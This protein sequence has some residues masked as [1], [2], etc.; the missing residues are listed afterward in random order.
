MKSIALIQAT[1]VTQPTDKG[2]SSRQMKMN[3]ISSEFPFQGPSLRVTPAAQ[4]DRGI[5][6]Q[7]VASQSTT[8][9]SGR[10][11]MEYT[12][13]TP[14]SGDMDH[15]R[16]CPGAKQQQRLA[17][18]LDGTTAQLPIPCKLLNKIKIVSAEYDEVINE[19]AASPPQPQVPGAFPFLYGGQKSELDGKRKRE[20]T[21]NKYADERR[22]S[23]RRRSFQNLDKDEK[24]EPEGPSDPFAIVPR[25]TSGP[26]LFGARSVTPEATTVA[27][28]SPRQ[29]TINLTMSKKGFINVPGANSSNPVE[30]YFA[31]HLEQ[32][33][34]QL[35]HKYNLLSQTH[36]FDVRPDRLALDLHA[37]RLNIEKISQTDDHEFLS[38]LHTDLVAVVKKLHLLKMAQRSPPA[39]PQPSR[40]YMGR[41]RYESGHPYIHLREDQITMSAPFQGPSGR[42]LRTV[43][44]D[45]WSRNYAVTVDV[46][47]TPAE[48]HAAMQLQVLNVSE[49][50]KRRF[51]LTVIRTETVPWDQL[52]QACWSAVKKIDKLVKLQPG[53]P[54]ATA[55]SDAAQHLSLELGVDELRTRAEMYA[56]YRTLIA[57]CL[58]RAKQF[59]RPRKKPAMDPMGKFKEEKIPMSCPGDH[60]TNL[61]RFGEMMRRRRDKWSSKTGW[62]DYTVIV[63]YARRAHM[64][65]QTVAKFFHSRHVPCK[66]IERTD[67]GFLVCVETNPGPVTKTHKG[68]KT[69]RKRTINVWEVK[70]KAQKESS[71]KGKDKETKSQDSSKR[72]QVKTKKVKVKSRGARTK[73]VMNTSMQDLKAQAQ[74]VHDT[75]HEIEKVKT[76]D[77]LEKLSEALSDSPFVDEEDEDS[78]DECV[79]CANRVQ[80]EVAE[81]ASDQGLVLKL[82]EQI[83]YNWL[84]P[85]EALSDI[86]LRM[87]SALI[88]TFYP[89]YS[90]FYLLSKPVSWWAPVFWLSLAHCL[91]RLVSSFITYSRR[92]EYDSSSYLSLVYL[93]LSTVPAVVLHLLGAAGIISDVVASEYLHIPS[94]NYMWLI[95]TALFA[96]VFVDA[97][98]CVL[99]GKQFFL[100][101]RPQ[102]RC[103]F[104]SFETT[105][106]LTDKRWDTNSRGPVLHKD[107]IPATFEFSTSFG[108]LDN[109]FE[110][111]SFVRLASCELLAQVTAPR[112]M[113]MITT[114]EFVREK[115]TQLATTLDS[116][117][118]SRYTAFKGD[119]IISNTSQVAMAFFRHYKQ[120]RDS[121]DFL[122]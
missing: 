30:P 42:W 73:A 84:A 68:D 5:V 100:A 104:V 50:D 107:P 85:E 114:E 17:S 93:L 14:I 91:F 97:W 71:N 57:G 53:L 24:E 108:W 25:G 36:L 102:H 2:I 3:F 74:A 13:V 21:A 120:R 7:E 43:Q 55:R 83:D 46:D 10:V 92:G 103:R 31:K 28:N 1:S 82:A 81:L 106:F 121:V 66:I 118:L 113:N 89:I 23:K 34:W 33:H 39:P 56:E 96:V 48:C 58:K 44:A 67:D 20:P 8:V 40:Y 51:W 15:G 35:L 65:V 94:Y 99:H 61:S 116:V 63:K 6:G 37:L 98:Y 27:G 32:R 87:F 59:D 75:K 12:G 45:S 110:K 4:A 88:A 11:A 109:F 16:G 19:M 86:S 54:R 49:I 70:D 41:D 60:Y 80:K 18:V 79:D 77:K 22:P 38:S 47:A 119:N 95:F 52:N 122:L 105:G 111:P 78:E 9:E 101:P 117:M 72:T 62:N 69:M 64:S 76:E 115:I 26:V 112:V 90:A 29:M